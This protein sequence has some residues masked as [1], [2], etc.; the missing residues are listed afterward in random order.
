LNKKK[1]FA[2]QL[3]DECEP[4]WKRE[5]YHH[6]FVRELSEG[7]LPR[8]KYE[9]YL[10][11]NHYYLMEYAKC[12]AIA[13]GRAVEEENIRNLMKLAAAAFDSELEKFDRFAL[14]FGVSR[15]RLDNVEPLAE[16]IG[17]VSYLHDICT[18]GNTGEAAA[19]LCP[20][21]WSYVEIA[22]K[23]AP[24]LTKYYGMSRKDASLYYSYMSSEYAALVQ[25]IRDMISQQA[26]G[27]RTEELERIREIFKTGTKFEKLFW[28]MAYKDKAT[29]D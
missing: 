21:A 4:T 28:D 13:A 23:V 19:A 17:Y 26:E 27:A 18:S 14:S 20:C 6:P 9:T 1:S 22:R 16:T 10:E 24:A 12:F 2:D 25:I 11:Q 3:K 15:K 7:K 8:K 29:D 5:L